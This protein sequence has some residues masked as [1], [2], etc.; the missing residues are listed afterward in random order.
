MVELSMMCQNDY[1]IK[2]KS[3]TTRN[4]QPNA[5]IER[6]HQ[7]IGNIIRTCDVS[8]IVKNDLWSG[9]IAATMF[10]VCATYHTTLQVSPFQIVFGRYAILNIKH[11]SNWSQIQQ[12]KQELINRNNKRKTYAQLKPPIQS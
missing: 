12:R 6:I 11:V 8:N 3:I 9:I 2:R 1:G 4:H 7:T 5:I 10:A